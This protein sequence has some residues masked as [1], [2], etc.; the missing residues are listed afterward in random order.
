VTRKI[1]VLHVV[2][3]VLSGGVERRRL[4]LAKHLGDD[5]EQ[6]LACYTARG[7]IA[8]EL[9]SLLPLHALSVRGK[10]LLSPKAHLRMHWLLTRWR[11]D[12]V[13]AAIFD[14]MFW[15]GLA[16]WL[17]RIP[18]V[19]L[20]ETSSVGPKEPKERQRSSRAAMAV[21]A[22]AKRTDGIVGVAPKVRDALLMHQQIPE[23]KVHLVM[24]GVSGFD[25][26]PRPEARAE[27][28]RLGFDDDAYVL[29]GV[30]RMHDH[31]K[32][33]S[34]LLRSVRAL[35]DRGRNVC[36]LIVGD[37]QDLESLKALAGE[38]DLSR[39]A[40]FTGRRE[41]RGLFFA[42][43]DAFVLSSATE[44]AP[45]SLIEGMMSGRPCIATVVGG[46]KDIAEH[47]S[48]ALLIPPLSPP[49]ITAAVERLL[50]DPQLASSLAAAGKERAVRKFSGQR[51]ARDVA[52]LY[53]G[54]LAARRERRRS[55]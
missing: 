39:H 42:M 40:V 22:L 29:G 25:V 37:G 7:P 12:I 11:P 48:S 1:R 28:R 9:S 23:A 21:R 54:R 27:R 33:F 26:A 2:P 45:L 50:D 32:R 15:G 51:Y 16:G 8:D 6:Q 55:R 3:Y 44:A 34:D 14:G 31:H 46:V 19:L 52:K 53:H 41:D 13:H 47:E 49:A 43:M 4:V 17:H 30:G 20:E 38:L 35:R 36:A 5:F 24:N 18:V 10:A